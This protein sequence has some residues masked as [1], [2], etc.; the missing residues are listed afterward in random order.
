MQLTSMDGKMRQKLKEILSHVFVFLTIFFFA[1]LIYRM[2][3][4][5][6]YLG[7]ENRILFVLIPL[8]IVLLYLYLEESED[9]SRL[10]SFLRVTISRLHESK[11]MKSIEGLW[12]R[13]PSFIRA[14]ISKVMA[15][16]YTY[17]L[18]QGPKQVVSN[19]FLGMLLILAL[20]SVIP[21]LSLRWART[22]VMIATVTLGTVTFY[23][24]RDKLYETKKEA[25]QEKLDENKRKMEFSEKY[26][27][28]DRIWGVRWI[29]KWM[30]KEGWWYSGLLALVLAISLTFMLNHLGQFM[31][32]DEPKWFITRVPQ[33]YESISTLNFEDTYINDKPGIL[34]AALAGIAFLFLDSSTYTPETFEHILFWWRLP[35]VLFNTFMLIIIYVFLKNLIHKDFAILCT[36]LIALNP[37]IIGISQIVNPDA[38]LWSTGF[39]SFLSYFIYLKTNNKKYAY[40]SGVF[41]GFA[42][43]SKYFASILYIIFLVAILI[44]YLS[45]NELKLNHL[46]T[47]FFDFII[48]STISIIIY[49]LLFPATWVNP[50]QIIKG[51]IGADILS[52]GLAFIQL[53]LTALFFDII[54]LKGKFLNYIRDYNILEKS[55][56]LIAIF[57]LMYIGYLMLNLLTDYKYFNLDQFL[58]HFYWLEDYPK[59]KILNSS[60]YMVLMT[61]IPQLLVGII[62]YLLIIAIKREKSLNKINNT[63]TNIILY[64]SLIFIVMFIV[65][66]SIGSYVTIMRY[67]IMLYPIYSIIA[68]SVM[69]QIFKK[70]DEI[71]I[72]TLA[73][74]ILCILI[75]FQSAPFYLHYN[76][77][78]N[79]KNSVISEAWG[80]GGYELAQIVNEMPDAENITV[81]SDREGFNEF[82]VGKT[83]WRGKDNPFELDDVDYLVLTYG[84]QKI[85]TTALYNWNRGSTYFYAHEAANTPILTYYNMTPVYQININGNCNNYVKLVPVQN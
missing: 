14:D 64:S 13:V 68:T 74:I 59:L 66:S 72:M 55:I 11:I 16:L 18:K 8:A 65:G 24:S 61:L 25:S 49:T 45:K 15:V 6:S 27:R 67:Q 3:N 19:A 85:F 20:E 17:M 76:N 69:L 82:F 9:R 30:Y 21:Q 32:V 7:L 53:G 79:Q 36:S 35:I 50:E 56:R 77:M 81:W 75:S 44:E 54:V 23:L 31:S 12:E 78:L 26:P 33:L 1:V 34:P 39:I 57:I 41:L 10:L 2:S 5:Y 38:T 46:Y 71:R 83:Y 43:L 22:P 47:R 60:S 62:I 52:P 84:G 63:I 28:I 37:V 51:T 42:L 48:F 70:K 29:G 58:L 40:I 73:S 80:Y 4:P